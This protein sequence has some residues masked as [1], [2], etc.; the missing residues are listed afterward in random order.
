M[1]SPSR[2]PAAQAEAARFVVNMWGT[3][4]AAETARM[5]ILEAKPPEGW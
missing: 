2:P 4:E 3:G 1:H 5:A